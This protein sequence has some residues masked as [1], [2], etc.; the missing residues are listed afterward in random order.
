MIVKALTQG[1]GIV[2][3]KGLGSGHLAADQS[4]EFVLNNRGVSS[5]VVGSLNLEHL[6]HNIAIAESTSFRASIDSQHF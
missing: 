6:K 5:L 4:I 1:V 3:K 2:V